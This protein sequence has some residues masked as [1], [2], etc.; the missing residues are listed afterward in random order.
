MIITKQTPLQ[1][2]EIRAI[3]RSQDIN[4]TC[5]ELKLPQRPSIPLEIVRAYESLDNPQDL[6]V[7]GQDPR[8][9]ALHRLAVEANRSRI[10]AKQNSS[11]GTQYSQV[12]NLYL[13]A[14]PRYRKRE[15]I[16]NLKPVF[17]PKLYEA[18]V[19]WDPQLE[20]DLDWLHHL[21]SR[22]LQQ[23]QKPV[24]SITNPRI[25]N[26]YNLVSLNWVVLLELWVCAPHLQHP[27]QL[28]DLL[29]HRSLGPQPLFDVYQTNETAYD[30]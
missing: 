25:R 22:V 26:H 8:N 20:L 30:L 11:W 1:P 5:T 23:H 18:L 7:W 6:A 2:A 13:L 19:C 27:N 4:K 15:W 24:D 28:L 17:H 14:H 9:W 12:V 21:R 16:S 29:G 10:I 3:Y